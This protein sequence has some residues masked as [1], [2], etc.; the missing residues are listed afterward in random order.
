M[1][2]INHLQQQRRQPLTAS[3]LGGPEEGDVIA[4]DGEDP[5]AL[6]SRAFSDALGRNAESYR[7]NPVPTRSNLDALHAA[8]DEGF[9]AGDPMA[10]RGRE[11]VQSDKL[12]I[13]E[14]RNFGR[15]GVADINADARRYDADA[16]RGV[17]TANA[18]G[19]VNSARVQGLMRQLEELRGQRGELRPEQPETPGTGL[20]GWFGV[21]SPAVPGARND[22]DRIDYLDTQ[23]QALERQLG[24]EPQDFTWAE[25]EEYAR[26]TGDSPENVQRMLEGRGHAVYR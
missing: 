11:A 13:E 9:I 14:A 4:A 2:Y 25:V 20:R 21:G 22:Q 5:T 1:A 23:S 26:E 3:E 18:G 7:Q 6:F 12:A 19:R 16:R 10:R 24:N 8:R 15:L 17:A